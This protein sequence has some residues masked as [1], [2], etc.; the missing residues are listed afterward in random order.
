M[1]VGLKGELGKESDSSCRSS[2][3]DKS[4]EERVG[5]V[6]ADSV[7]G[8]CVV[9]IVVVVVERVKVVDSNSRSVVVKWR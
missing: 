3:K 4:M 7:G 6:V 9:G 5:F 8:G 1:A 2:S